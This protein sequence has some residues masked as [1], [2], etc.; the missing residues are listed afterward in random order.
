ME[1][2][3][4]TVGAIVLFGLLFIG[5]VFMTQPD[6][7]SRETVKKGKPSPVI[8]GRI[9]KPQPEKID[10]DAE[11][12]FTERPSGLKYR[13]LRKSDKAKPTHQDSVAVAYKG[14]T[15]GGQVFDSSY[16]RDPPYF[17]L[18]GGGWGVIEGWKEGIPLC[19]EGGMLELEIPYELAYG[20]S[21]HGPKIGP[22]AT[23]WFQVEVLKIFS[24]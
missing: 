21:G 3:G 18:K 16:G 24:N 17:E 22:K 13:I 9:P 10:E 15:K 7:E 11:T 6:P 4:A 1:Y 5:A 23:L 8:S 2:K 14:W 19:G 12:E 20:E